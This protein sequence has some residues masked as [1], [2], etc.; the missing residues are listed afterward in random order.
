[1]ILEGHLAEGEKVRERAL[2]EQFGVSRTPLREALKVLASE[3][4]LQLIP[5]RG[6]VISRQTDAELAE[7]FPVLAALEG[8][9]GELAAARATVKEMAQ[10][11][12]LT[13]AMRSAYKDLNRPHYFEA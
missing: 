2:T 13:V 11:E 3:G 10:I 6:A 4:L 1:M 12:R 5:N 9:A 7:A 8:T